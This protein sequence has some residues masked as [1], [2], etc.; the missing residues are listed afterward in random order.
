VVLGG[1]IPESDRSN[2]L[3]N[4]VTAIYTPKDFDIARIMR[5]IAEIAATYRKSQK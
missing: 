2:L 3:T 4:G 5:D 1:I